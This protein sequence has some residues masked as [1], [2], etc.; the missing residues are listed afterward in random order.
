MREFILDDGSM[1][2]LPFDVDLV[3]ATTLMDKRR[4]FLAVPAGLSHPLEEASPSS[5]LQAGLPNPAGPGARA[6]FF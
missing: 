1:L 5:P 2:E 3:E 4:R 6:G